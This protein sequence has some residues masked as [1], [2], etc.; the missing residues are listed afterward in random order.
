MPIELETAEV[1]ID[2]VGAEAVQQTLDALGIQAGDVNAPA[3]DTTALAK[4]DPQ[5]PDPKAAANTD[6][7][8]DL[9]ALVAEQRQTNTLLERLIELTAQHQHSAPTY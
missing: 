5:R 6:D 4:D 9:S 3:T 8:L 1:T 7:S 2:T